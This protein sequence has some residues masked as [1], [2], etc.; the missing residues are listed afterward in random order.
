MTLTLAAKD[1]SVQKVSKNREQNNGHQEAENEFEGQDPWQQEADI[2]TVS[3]REH[4][5]Y[6]IRRDEDRGH[7][8]GTKPLSCQRPYARESI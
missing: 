4:C 7:C 3:V 8:G 5:T 1:N 2:S 6:V